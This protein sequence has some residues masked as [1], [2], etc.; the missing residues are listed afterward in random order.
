MNGSRKAT[1][2]NDTR[3][4]AKHRGGR[5]WPGSAT[6]ALDTSGRV[7]LSVGVV[8][9]VYLITAP[10]GMLLITAFRGPEQVLPFEP[11]AIWSLE[12][13]RAVYS[14]PI[15]YTRVLPQTLVFAC[16]SVTITTL[17]AFVLA[18]LIERTDLPGRDVWYALILFPLLVPSVILGIAW[19]WLFG[20][21]AGWVNVALRTLWGTAGSGPIQLFSMPG[22]ILCQA[23]A[24]APFMFLMFCA[25]LRAMNPTLEEASSLCGATPWQS[26]RRVTLPVLLPGIAA[27]IMLSLLIALEQFEM[28]L[29]IGLP[30]GIN[31]F[32]IRVF[33]E[34][35]PSSGLPNYGA[36]AAVS[37]P[38]LVIGF[39]LL[40]LYNF[41]I[42]RADRYVTVIGK[43]YRPSRISLRC[44]RWPALLAVAAYVA[45]AAV[46][47]ALVLVW[48]SLAGYAVPSLQ[49]FTQIS[50]AAYKS[51]FANERVG[52]AVFN[53]LLVAGL[54]AAIA[55]SIGALLAWLIARHRFR[56]R[57][58]IDTLSF[59][60]IAIPAVIAG[61]GL[62]L[63]YLS[64]PVG[65]Y[66]TVW[67]LVLAYSYRITTSTRINRAGL[68]Q[69]HH[70]LEEASAMSGAM[71][72]QTMR[73]VVWPL[74]APSLA[75]S[76]VLLFI[77]GFREFTLPMLLGSQENLVLS[78]ILWRLF[79]AGQPAPT[80][81]LGTLMILI[82]IPIVFALRRVTQPSARQA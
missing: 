47:P 77:L 23:L 65:I 5:V 26:F 62:M 17:I 46:L 73:R 9:A 19:I 54:S 4:S 56:G 58:L 61:L 36:A 57:F 22:L 67:L 41:F 38:F 11:G 79:E 2:L 69:L 33:Y 75:A 12:H 42:R 6:Q 64:L 78:V 82:V 50:L 31:V 30:A 8:L 49:T 25:V 3:P 21:N 45:L 59:V 60:S 20:P 68:M 28:P 14:D 27:P 51:L 16:G 7:V 48:I 34:L 10:L 63:F 74:V 37:V 80:A 52:L 70:E 53:T 72:A 55:T 40:A 1:A 35:S 76:F 32:S 18:W 44:W 13:F 81:A 29:I 24:T 15:L 39:G 66:G 71:W 43:A